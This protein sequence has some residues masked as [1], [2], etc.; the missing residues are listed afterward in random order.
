[1]SDASMKKHI[2]TLLSGLTLVCATQPSH[3]AL[4][5]GSDTRLG[6]ASTVVD[7]SSG[8]Q[9][10]SLSET[11][12][13][14][15]QDVNSRLNGSTAWANY[16]WATEA[17]ILGLFA[18]ASIPDLNDPGDR[19]YYGTQANADAVASLIQLLGSTYSALAGGVRISSVSGLYGTIYRSSI[20]GFDSVH[21]AELVL[22]TNVPMGGGLTSSY[23]SAATRWSAWGSQSANEYIG[24]WLVSTVPEPY[25]IWMLTCSLGLLGWMGRRQRTSR[26]DLA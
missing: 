19:A 1:M 10:L 21:M 3:A 8:L 20:N 22:R 13:L 17:E 2:A 5:T 12:G 9:W 16:R 25:S 15:Y 14:S 24:S 26:S 7:T 18:E 11:A 23:G 6:R 4:I